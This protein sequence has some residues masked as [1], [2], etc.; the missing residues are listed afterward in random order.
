MSRQRE[1]LYSRLVRIH[2]GKLKEAAVRHAAFQL[3]KMGLYACGNFRYLLCQREFKAYN[4][5]QECP[6]FENFLLVFEV[7]RTNNTMLGLDRSFI[8]M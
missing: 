8:C 4:S 1:Y 7:W 3:G 6:L 5:L 2:I